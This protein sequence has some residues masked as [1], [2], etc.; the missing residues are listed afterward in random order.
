MRNLLT[1]VTFGT[2]VYISVQWT[3]LLTPLP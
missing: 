3:A 2:F 1:M